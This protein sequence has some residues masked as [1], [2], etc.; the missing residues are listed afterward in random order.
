MKPN[1]L[2]NK[3]TKHSEGQEIIS[4]ER[5]KDCVDAL[6][7]GRGVAIIMTHLETSTSL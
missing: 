1:P 5:Q 7:E 6:S 3:N 2:W 4:Q